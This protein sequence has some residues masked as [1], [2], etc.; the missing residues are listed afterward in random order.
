MFE[1]FDRLLGSGKSSLM[2]CW[3]A[4]LRAGTRWS[5]RGSLRRTP[6]FLS[7]HHGLAAYRDASRA[8]S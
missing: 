4:A 7:L 3:P 1:N 6:S 8:W 5:R 2:M